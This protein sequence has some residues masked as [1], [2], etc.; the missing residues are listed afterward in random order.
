MRSAGMMTVEA[1]TDLDATSRRATVQRYV[2][3]DALFIALR[4]LRF[5]KDTVK[6]CCPRVLSRITD[7]RFALWNRQSFT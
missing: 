7:I 5:D 4:A 3:F 1:V 2:S 6:G